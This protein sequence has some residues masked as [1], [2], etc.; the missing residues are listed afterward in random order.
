MQGVS[1]SYLHDN[2]GAI[3]DWEYPEQFYTWIRSNVKTVV[4]STV[5]LFTIIIIIYYYL[6]N[7][8]TVQ[9][10]YCD[11]TVLISFIDTLISYKHLE[12][13]NGFFVYK[14]FKRTVVLVIEN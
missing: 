9:K 6:N 12:V 14:I 5:L 11:K 13:Y 1:G 4:I 10:G 3:V 8:T 2:C 7:E